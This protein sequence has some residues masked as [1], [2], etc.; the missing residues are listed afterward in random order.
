[1]DSFMWLVV[2]SLKM[3]MMGRTSLQKMHETLHNL[4]ARTRLVSISLHV[5]HSKFWLFSR[6]LRSYVICLDLQHTNT[7]FSS[8]SCATTSNRI[9]SDSPGDE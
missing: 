8:P 6:H 9:G 5:H 4:S 1:M 3:S 2:S 7:H